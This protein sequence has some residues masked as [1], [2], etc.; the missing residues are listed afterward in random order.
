MMT[1]IFSFG[2]QLSLI[3]IATLALFACA[4]FAAADY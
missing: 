1:L 3:A 2:F 4:A